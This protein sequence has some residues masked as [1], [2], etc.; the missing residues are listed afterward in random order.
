MGVNDVIVVNKLPADVGEKLKLEKV[1][2][3]IQYAVCANSLD[4]CNMLSVEMASM[5]AI[6]C[7]WKWFIRMQFVACMEMTLMHA[8]FCLRKG[9][10]F[11]LICCL[12]KWLRR[13]QY[14]VYE[15]S[16]DACNMFSVRGIALDKIISLSFSL[17][18]F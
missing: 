13:M 9:F 5:H 10:T 7:L 15:N 8:I 11:H 12:W 4:A 1:R 3:V 16:L 6:C 17:S 18:L 14:V 2:M